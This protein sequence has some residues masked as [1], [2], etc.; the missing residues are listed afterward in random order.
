M[1]GTLV[2]TVAVIAG[3]CIGLAARKGISE[4]VN[5]AVTKVLGLSTCI[6]GLNGV[7][8]TMLSVT[9]EGRISSSGELLLLC[10][11][12]IGTVFGEWLR[13]EERLETLGN[14]IEQRVG[15]SGFSK[16]FVS[17]S[18]LFCVGA[19]TIVGAIN[20]GLLGDSRM[21]FIKSALDFTASIILASALGVGVPCAA[22]VVLLYQGALTLGAGALAGVLTGALLD[23][24]CMVGY[25]I[26]ICIGINF[27]GVVKIKT[28]NLLPSLLVPVVC[29]LLTLLKTL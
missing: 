7:L 25:A 16:G 22:V 11:L 19:M 21:L 15:A 10:S 4:R 9:D 3:G 6:I 5:D 20:D 13:L 8:S 26:C 17:A 12:A 28:A 18:L 1:T 24:I 29:S 14:K 27:F 2:N 23:Q